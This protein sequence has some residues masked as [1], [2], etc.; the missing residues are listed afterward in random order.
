MVLATKQWGPW[1]ALSNLSMWFK[2]CLPEK[3]NYKFDFHFYFLVDLIFSESMPLQYRPSDK[4][5][6]LLPLNSPN[7]GKFGQKEKLLVYG[8]GYSIS[9]PKSYLDRSLCF[10][11]STRVVTPNL[12]F[13]NFPN[14]TLK[15]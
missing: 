2:F 10:K 6:Q 1:V 7:S 14:L 3:N 15:R 9:F 4:R 13:E 12:K 5:F 8:T 11:S